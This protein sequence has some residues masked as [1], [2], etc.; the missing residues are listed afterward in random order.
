MVIQYHTEEQITYRKTPITALVSEYVEGERLNDFLYRQ[1][2]KR[3]S[4]FQAV[5]LL[6]ALTVGIEEIHNLREYLETM[7]WPLPYIRIE[8]SFLM[9]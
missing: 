6:Y 5:H 4:S 3:L 1:P 9:L 7:R 8:L 2:G